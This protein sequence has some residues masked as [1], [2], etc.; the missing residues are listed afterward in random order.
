VKNLGVDLLKLV[1]PVG[2]SHVARGAQPQI[3]LVILVT[4]VRNR[5]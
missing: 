3:Q 2:V 4:F 5:W 1:V